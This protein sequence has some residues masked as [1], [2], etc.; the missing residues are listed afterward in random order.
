MKGAG[1]QGNQE[2]QH[3][4]RLC[5]PLGHRL[6]QGITQAP[7]PPT[8]QHAW[9]WAPDQEERFQPVLPK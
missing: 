7:P 1:H 3:G 9:A 4:Y 5:S 8:P 6:S 2:E